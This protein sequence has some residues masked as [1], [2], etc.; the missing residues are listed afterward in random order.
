MLEELC[1]DSLYKA[2]HNCVDRARTVYLR[3]RCQKETRAFVDFF[4]GYPRF[5]WH[6]IP[7]SKVY[8]TRRLS[9]ERMAFVWF[10][11]NADKICGAF[12]EREY[13]G[14]L[15]LAMMLSGSFD[16]L[17]DEFKAYF[18]ERRANLMERT[19]NAIDER[20]RELSSCGKSPQSHGG[21][22]NLLKVLTKTMQTQGSSIYSIAK[23]QYAVC[24][25]AGIYIPDEF[26]TDVIAAAEIMSGE[27]IECGQTV[28]KHKT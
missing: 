20:K 15:T 4:G 2:C 22:A 10:N 7:L 3:G 12:I 28:S 5:N 1:C 19:E 9:V 24:M 26:L 17:F 25:Q 14:D 13:G 21:V 11:E 18:T 16:K 8:S 27:D 23:V 6:A